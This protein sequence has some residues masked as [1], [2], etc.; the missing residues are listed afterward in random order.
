MQQR[1]GKHF[2]EWMKRVR[3]PKQGGW[4]DHP[5][6]TEPASLVYLAGQACVTLH[7]WLSRADRLDR[8]DL[9]IV[10][11]DPSEGA[12]SHMRRAARL[13][14]EQLQE[15][16]LEPWIMS[17]GSRGYHVVVPLQRR[18]TFD[19]LRPFARDLAALLAVRQRGLFTVEQRKAK[20]GGRILLDVM[21]NTFGH[22][23]VAPY[24]VRA[25]AGAP[26]A[27]PL[28]WEELEDRGTRPD[29]WSIRDI[30][31]RLERD[32]D[33]WVQIGRQA[34]TIARARTLLEQALDAIQRPATR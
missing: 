24:A 20:R 11:L 5:L 18:S 19:R 27:T 30:P 21:R 22:T 26:V 3:V 4:V 8:P 2:P 1:A 15:L 7:R 10:D 13:V 16:E 9:L 28:H 32:G 31:R 6:A 29:R 23:A 25:R 34:N 33:P 17:T 12:T 14:R